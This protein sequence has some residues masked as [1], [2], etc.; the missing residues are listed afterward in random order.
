MSTQHY[1]IRDPKHDYIVEPGHVGFTI[2]GENVK[3]N[4]L[5]TKESRHCKK[6]D[7][8]DVTKIADALDEISIIYNGGNHEAT[9]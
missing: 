1:I 4:D 8:C 3:V 6:Q 9:D 5:Y 2:F 7:L